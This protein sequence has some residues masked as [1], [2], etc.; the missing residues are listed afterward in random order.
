MKTGVLRARCFFQ[1]GLVRPALLG[2]FL[3]VSL[4]LFGCD[5]AKNILKPARS[6]SEITVQTVGFGTVAE[7][8][9]AAVLGRNYGPDEIAITVNLDDGRV[10]IIVQPEDNIFT[11]GDRVRVLRDAKGLARAEIVL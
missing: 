7:V 1:R 5:A 11:R 4:P 3:L 10:V 6:P 2:C 9:E 8:T